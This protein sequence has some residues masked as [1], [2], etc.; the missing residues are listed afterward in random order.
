VGQAHVFDPKSRKLNR[1]YAFTTCIRAEGPFEFS[2]ISQPATTRQ[3]YLSA[4]RTTITSAV[5]RVRSLKTPAERIAIHLP[6][7]F[8]RE[9]REVVSAAAVPDPSKPP[10][11]IDVLQVTPE[12][13]FFALDTASSNGLPPR[14]I[15]VA[16]DSSTMLLYTEG[17]DE[18]Q[19]WQN[20]LPTALRVRY[21]GNSNQ[22]VLY[23]LL[24]QI[25]DLSQVNY[26]GF[27]AASSPVSLVYSSLVA[28][29]LS[30]L[31]AAWIDRLSAEDKHRLETRMW[32][33]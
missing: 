2:V 27:N 10:I 19:P 17:R 23:D 9:E 12:E 15:C 1:Q 13:D 22:Q 18:L 31:P 16:L 24:S 21:F 29:L 25:L 4:L 33:L 8:G 6:K 26:R 5:D 11:Q 32:F 20:R 3:E 28:K 30:H 14:G 7:R